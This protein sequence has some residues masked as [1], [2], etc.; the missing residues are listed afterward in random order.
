MCPHFTR[1]DTLVQHREHDTANTCK[2]CRSFVAVLDEVC[3]QIACGFPSGQASWRKAMRMQI[4]WRFTD[5]LCNQT[6]WDVLHSGF[7]FQKT[8][9]CVNVLEIYKFQSSK[10]LQN[11]HRTLMFHKNSQRS[12]QKVDRHLEIKAW[13]YRIN[14]SCGST[15]AHPQKYSYAGAQVLTTVATE[16]N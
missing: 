11:Q 9:M 7:C 6:H 8:E 2:C 4:V 10:I 3:T 13:Y 15:P 14:T 5:L 16:C 1:E 12:P